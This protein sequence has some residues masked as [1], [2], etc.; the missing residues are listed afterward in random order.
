[1]L[2]A[3]SL[4]IPYARL[5]LIEDAAGNTSASQAAFEKAKEIVREHHPKE[6]VTLVKIKQGLQ[7]YD[8]ALGMIRY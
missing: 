7:R 6:E 1:M 5:A 8:D 3:R 4:Y 2:S